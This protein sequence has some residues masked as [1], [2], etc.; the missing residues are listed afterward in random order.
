VVPNLANPSF[1][2][3]IYFFRFYTTTL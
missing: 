1:L 2:S 3:C